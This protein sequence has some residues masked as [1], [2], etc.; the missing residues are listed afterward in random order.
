MKPGCDCIVCFN[1]E[2]T[3]RL[4]KKLSELSARVKELEAGISREGEK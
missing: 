4:V 3:E 1:A 2:L